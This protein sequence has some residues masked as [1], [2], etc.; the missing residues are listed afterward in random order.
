MRAYHAQANIL[1]LTPEIIPSTFDELLPHS[2]F[3]HDLSQYAAETSSEKALEVYRRLVERQPDDPPD[4]VIASDT[5]IVHAEQIFEKPGTR[6]HTLRMLQ[7]FNGRTHEVWTAVTVVA[8][9]VAQPGFTVKSVNQ[10]EAL[11][12]E[13]GSFEKPKADALSTNKQNPAGE[14]QHYLCRQ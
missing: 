13:S 8:P 9:Q 6:D 5:V 10:R 7:D 12:E 1:G 2:S 3:A 4:L 11:S 14:V